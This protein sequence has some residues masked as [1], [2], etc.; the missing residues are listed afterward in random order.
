MVGDVL[1]VDLEAEITDSL[2][3][4]VVAGIEAADTTTGV[5]TI[6]GI[7]IVRAPGP[8]GGRTKNLISV[9]GRIIERGP[10]YIIG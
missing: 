8:T 3:A 9:G 4:A 6:V 7:I 2:G 1:V 5:T 10:I